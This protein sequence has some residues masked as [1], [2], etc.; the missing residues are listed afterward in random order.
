MAKTIQKSFFLTFGRAKKIGM[1]LR[2]KTSS[3]FFAR[4]RIH[5]T[6]FVLRDGYKNFE[7]LRLD[8]SKCNPSPSLASATTESSKQLQCSYLVFST[9][10]SSLFLSL[11]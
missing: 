6:F 8:F 7:N 10:T 4:R 5:G 11:H 9:Q 1:K 2:T 3:S